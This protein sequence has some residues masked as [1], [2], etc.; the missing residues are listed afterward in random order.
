MLQLKLRTFI[1]SIM[2][3]GLAAAPAAAKGGGGRGGGHGHGNG[4]HG[5]GPPAHAH[6][7]GRGHAVAH[8]HAV[9]HG[10]ALRSAVVV[11]RVAPRQRVVSSRVV[12]LAPSRTQLVTT[13]PAQV[14]TTR[15]APVVVFADRDREVVHRYYVESSGRG[16][17]PPGLARKNNG[18]LPPGQAAKLYVVGQPLA[19]T[20][21]VNPLP[22][23]L[24]QR[25]GPAPVGYEYVM[26]DG[27][28]LKLAVGTRLV[29][30]AIR[31]LAR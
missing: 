27:D 28:V 24:V 22:P 15:T 29:V 25:L 19:R 6:G 1:A 12:R 10:Q 21:V 23:V 5:G 4:H 14:V 16:D 3:L 17:C 11:T 8:G 2:V 7:N 18:C 13:R 31:Y 20:V 9:V 26:V 30:D